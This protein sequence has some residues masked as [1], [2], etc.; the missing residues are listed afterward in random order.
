MSI[1]N[2]LQLEIEKSAKRFLETSQN[3]EIQIISHFDTDGITSAAI[4]IQAL[5]RLDRNFS[6]KIIKSLDKEFIDYLPKNKLTIFLDLASNS[7]KEISE[8][9][10]SEA[11]I[12]DH[13]EISQEIPES[14]NIVNPHLNTNSKISAAG[15]TYLFCKELDKRNKEFAK[16]AVLGMIGD[17]LESEIGKLNN[18][19]LEDGEIKRKRGLL[20]YPSTRPLNR[21]L[22][23]CSNPFIPGVTGDSQGVIE[24]LREVSL[25]PKHGN[26]PSLIELTDEEMEKLV[27]AVTL[28]VPKKI[29]E[30]IIGDIFLI[31]MF[32]KLEDARELSAMINACSRLGHPEIALQLCMEISS[33]KKR[34]ESIHVKYKQ[35]I[36]TGLKI[37]SQ[38]EEI[39]KIEKPGFVLINAKEKIKET[40]IGTIASIISSSA[41]YKEGTIIIAMA[42]S[43]D[44][45]KISLRAVGQNPRNLRK[46]ISNVMENFEGE[47]GGHEQAAGAVIKKED[48]GLF[49]EKIQKHLEVEVVRV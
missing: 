37:S 8:S 44:K 5:K 48:E 45:I 34:A 14:I 26:Y 40:I 32:N 18:G 31:K 9:G 12:I 21:T 49:I 38:S 29:H 19:I 42:Y 6:V 17:R 22:E 24:L 28:R 47:V 20:I 36:V 13:H 33:A 35:H 7:L 27:T 3:K 2:S 15:L 25:I 4:M 1:E 10:F 43:D 23:Y 39:Q 11:F 16:L 46:L 41:T 30:K